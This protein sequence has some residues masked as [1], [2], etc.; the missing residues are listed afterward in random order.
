MAFLRSALSPLEIENMAVLEVGSR[1]VN[2]SPRTIISPMGPACYIG[3]DAEDGPGVDI[4]SDAADL[5]SALSHEKVD[6]VI[7]TEM[8]EH[9]KDWRA[10]V[11]AMKRVLVP[12]GLL[13]VTTRGPGFPRHDYPGDY[14]RYTVEDFRLIFRDMEILTLEPDPQAG[15][16]GVFLKARR[17][18]VFAEAN[19]SDLTIKGV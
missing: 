17:P 4:I 19:L 14:W 1:D 12:G 13:L 6:I 16:P 5:D 9:A 15:H 7:S 11:S 3:V 2:G 8:L 10:V 18:E